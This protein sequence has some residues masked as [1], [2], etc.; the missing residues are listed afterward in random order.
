MTPERVRHSFIC[1]LALV[2]LISSGVA[3]AQ[4][5]PPKLPVD[6]REQLNK[7]DDKVLEKQRELFAARQRGDQKAVKRLTKEFN[8]IQKER[9]GL[10]QKA[11]DLY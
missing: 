1:A 2:G 6:P 11:R 4:S 8:Q 5:A 10:V 3:L 9:G 7:L